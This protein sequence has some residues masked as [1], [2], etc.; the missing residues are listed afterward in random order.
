M[1]AQAFGRLVDQAMTAKGMSQDRLAVL[2]GELPDGRV[3]NGK[4]VSRIREGQRR[5]DTWLVGRLIE[6][7]DLDPPA[8]WHAAGLWPE[9]LDPEDVRDISE[10]RAARGEAAQR[11]ASEGAAASASP[12][13]DL[14]EPEI[15]YLLNRRERPAA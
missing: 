15:L 13:S 10:S 5:L 2:V 7:L 12:I 11:A 4:Q 1:G 6:L 14:G 8:A 9:G 3:L